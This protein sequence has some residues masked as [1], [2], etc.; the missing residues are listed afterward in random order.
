MSVSWAITAVLKYCE[1]KFQLSNRNICRESDTVVVVVDSSVDTFCSACV[2]TF[3]KT[4]QAINISFP[5]FNFYNASG[6]DLR[7]F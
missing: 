3:K 6:L 4:K 5:Y 1:S 7:V 2:A